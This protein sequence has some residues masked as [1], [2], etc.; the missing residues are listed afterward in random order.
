MA[1][2]SNQIGV[3]ALALAFIGLLFAC[4]SE[5]TLSWTVYETT[6][7]SFPDCTMTMKQ[8]T[9]LYVYK[10][11]YEVKGSSCASL[12][13]T[14]ETNTADIN[15]D[16]LSTTDCERL[17]NTRAGSGLAVATSVISLILFIVAKFVT[18]NKF[19]KF[20]NA[21]FLLAGGLSAWGAVGEWSKLNQSVFGFSANHTSDYGFSWDLEIAVGF[22]MIIAAILV[23]VQGFLPSDSGTDNKA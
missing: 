10:N 21:V 4:I 15:C 13:L 6:D 11:Y 9:G 7:N 20:G 12:G 19:V 22:L 3:A 18:E 14:D 16:F 1:V 23:T 2:N 17:N 8:N 5:G